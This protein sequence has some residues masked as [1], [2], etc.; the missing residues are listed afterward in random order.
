MSCAGKGYGLNPQS[1]NHLIAHFSSNSNTTTTPNST[2]KCRKFQGFYPSFVP[3]IER[4]SIS[5]SKSN[6]YSEVHILGTNFLPNNTTFIKFGNY[7]YLPA[8]YYTSFNISFIVP[9]NANLG[10]YYIQVVNIYN[11]NFSL[12]VNQT[13]PGNL[14]LSNSV[15]YIIN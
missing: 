1:D 2:R 4:I 11:N 10:N 13:S 7:G 15:L 3:T 12:P 6:V 5:S 9:L 14:N 8:T